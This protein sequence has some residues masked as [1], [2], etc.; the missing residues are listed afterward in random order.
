MNVLENN[1]EK[2]LIVYDDVRSKIRDEE[3]YNNKD[4]GRLDISGVVKN[5][6]NV[7]GEKSK[8]EKR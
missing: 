7:N 2:F 6:K 4:F 8:V 1:G 5:F 3:G